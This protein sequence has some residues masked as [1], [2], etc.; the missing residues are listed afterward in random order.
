MN[1]SHH[2]IDNLTKINTRLKISGFASLKVN[3]F[4][5]KWETYPPNNL[6]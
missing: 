3:Q 2:P 1:W 6:P 5:A 4:K